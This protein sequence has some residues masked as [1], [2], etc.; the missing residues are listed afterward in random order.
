MFLLTFSP[1]V[2]F[3]KPRRNGTFLFASCLIG[4]ND[5]L[6]CAFHAFPMRFAGVPTCLPEYC[7]VEETLKKR[8]IH[9]II[10]VTPPYQPTRPHIGIAPP[11][12]CVKRMFQRDKKKYELPYQETAIT[13]AGVHQVDLLLISHLEKLD[14][15]KFMF[16]DLASPQHY[17]KNELC[18][19]GECNCLD[20][21]PIWSKIKLQ[22]LVPSPVVL[23]NKA[24]LLN[25]A[26]QEN[27][28]ERTVFGLK[29][30]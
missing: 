20:I 26:C 13:C 10:F 6:Q 16:F 11:R 12:A 19:S 23:L 29:K 7:G 8:T 4:C 15:S 25:K 3:T 9:P 30:D 1:E 18:F 17:N 21:D 27:R 22:L 2:R 14:L 24:T 28:I 5:A